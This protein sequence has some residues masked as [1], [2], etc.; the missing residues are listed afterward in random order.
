MEGLNNSGPEVCEDCGKESDDIVL[1]FCP[2]CLELVVLDI[3]FK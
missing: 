1:G 2:E 3:P